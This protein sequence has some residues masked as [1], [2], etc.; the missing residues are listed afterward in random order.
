M[1]DT[2]TE[3]ERSRLWIELPDTSVCDIE[4]SIATRRWRCMDRLAFKLRISRATAPAN[5]G[6]PEINKRECPRGRLARLPI[7]LSKRKL[8][9]KVLEHLHNKNFRYIVEMFMF[10]HIYYRFVTDYGTC[11]VLFVIISM[12][13]VVS[14]NLNAKWFYDRQY[15]Q[16]SPT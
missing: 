16:I 13:I 15:V 9:V 1:R 11:V 3:S 5:L 2:T 4:C 6:W 8:N 10:F 7:L 12:N 14:L